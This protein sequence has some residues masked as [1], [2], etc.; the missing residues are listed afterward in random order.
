MRIFYVTLND[1][2]E[3]R[4]VAR[5]LLTRR[6]AVCCNWFPITCAYVLHDEIKEGPEVVLIVKSLAEKREAVRAAVAEVIDYTNFVG[7]IELDGVND[8]FAAWLK[9]IVG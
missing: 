4:A 3:A 5:L 1:D 7:E 2:G 6:D 9:G 8:G